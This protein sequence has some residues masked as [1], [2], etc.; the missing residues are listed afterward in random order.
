MKRPAKCRHQRSL[1][2]VISK[3][4][5]TLVARSVAAQS[6]ILPNVVHAALTK[7]ATHEFDDQ[8]GFKLA[9]SP[10]PASR[11]ELTTS[12]GSERL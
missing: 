1:D 8:I 10:R 3:R 2:A 6:G 7:R 11:A 12:P 9:S 4:I 5:G